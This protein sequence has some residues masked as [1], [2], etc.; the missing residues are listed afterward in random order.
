MRAFNIY[1][2]MQQNSDYDYAVVAGNGIITDYNGVIETRYSLDK[3][4][5]CATLIELRTLRHGL[6]ICGGLQPIAISVYS[7]NLNIIEQLR[8]TKTKRTTDLVSAYSEIEDLLG[9]LDVPVHF[10]WIPKNTMPTWASYFRQSDEG[11]L[12]YA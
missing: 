7:S 11:G 4:Y 5:G 1:I 9:K 10:Q 3:E 8:G 12:L 6:Q 2:S